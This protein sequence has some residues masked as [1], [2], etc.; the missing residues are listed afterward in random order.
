MNISPKRRAFAALLG[1]KVDKTP[2]TSIGGCWGATCVDIQRITG[3]FLRDAHYSPKKMTDLAIASQKLTGLESVRVP[4]DVVVEPEIF[5]C[6]INWGTGPESTPS[7]S[8]FLRLAPENLKMPENLLEKGRI[9][10][11]L[12]AIRL[13]REEVGDFLPISSFIQGPFTFAGQLV[14]LANLSK[15][16]EIKP[17]L[18]RMTID[19]ATT[20]AIDYGKAQYRAGADI[21]DVGDPMASE[22]LISPEKFREFVK[23]ALSELTKNLGG[24]KVL[25]I[26]GQ[27]RRLLND[28]AETGFD[29]INLSEDVEID[30]VKALTSDIKTLG[31]VSSS[32]TLIFGSTND[33]KREAIKS[34]KAGVDLLEP[35]CG[36]SSITPLANI[37]AMVEARDEFFTEASMHTEIS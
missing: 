24:I 35:T 25:R 34:L 9:P 12:D 8:K 28:I 18:A 4:F 26:C 7:V 20:I 21:V 14:G 19:F 1:G 17:K 37:R 3:I 2:V 5:G 10:I 33:I 23:P 30:Y 27:T 13:V 6:K 29:G 36:F 11:V 22:E 16:I 31:K 15:W 32:R